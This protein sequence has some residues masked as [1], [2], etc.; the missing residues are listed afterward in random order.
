MNLIKKG[1]FYKELRN[2]L[3]RYSI[4]NDSNTPDFILAEYLLSCLETFNTIVMQRS[5]WYGYVDKI[6]IGEIKP[7]LEPGK[8]E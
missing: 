1:E 2:L 7:G 8:E 3:N 4:E 6:N 5:K